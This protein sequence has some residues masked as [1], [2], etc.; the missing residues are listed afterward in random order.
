M[1]ALQSLLLLCFQAICVP[2]GGGERSCACPE[3]Y[4]GDGM[5]CYGDVL[6]VSKEKI[7]EVFLRSVRNGFPPLSLSFSLLPELTS[8][9]TRQHSLFL[10][11][12][13]ETP[14]VPRLMCSINHWQYFPGCFTPVCPVQY[15]LLLGKFF[16]SELARPIFCH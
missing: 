4:V 2:L 15:S 14:V 8:P 6:K 16:R 10:L 12:T 13:T 3:G 1:F 7:S 9:S 5:T 11:K